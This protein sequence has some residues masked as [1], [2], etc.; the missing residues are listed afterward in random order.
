M[1]NTSKRPDANDGTLANVNKFSALHLS[2]RFITV[3][4]K[5]LNRNLFES[6]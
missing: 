1:K 6:G 2:G 5:D 3:F 4:T